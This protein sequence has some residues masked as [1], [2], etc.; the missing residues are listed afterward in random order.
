M[1]KKPEIELLVDSMATISDVIFKKLQCFVATQ[2]E[3]CGKSFMNALDN[4]RK[5]GKI[6]R[7]P[8]RKRAPRRAHAKRSK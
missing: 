8:R 3:P 1:P 7:A 5:A 6:Q 2:C 4:L